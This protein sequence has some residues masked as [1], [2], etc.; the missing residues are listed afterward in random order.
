VWGGAGNGEVGRAW[1][2]VC[3]ASWNSCLGRRDERFECGRWKG[4]GTWG[5][6]FTQYNGKKSK[7]GA[8]GSIWFSRENSIM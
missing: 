5:D 4:A 3:G 7:C 6:I 1:V 2:S 8:R